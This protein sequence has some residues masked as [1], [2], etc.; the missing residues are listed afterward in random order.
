MGGGNRKSRSGHMGLNGKFGGSSIVLAFQIIVT[1][2]AIIAI[3]VI[4]GKGFLFTLAAGL[5]IILQ[6]FLGAADRPW[7]MRHGSIETKSSDANS[8]QKR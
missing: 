5:K 6:L 2:I 7:H 1:I 4:T 3:I 8:Q